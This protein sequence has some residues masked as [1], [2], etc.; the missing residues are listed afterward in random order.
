MNYSKNISKAIF[1]FSLALLFTFSSCKKDE[2]TPDDDTEIT[3]LPSV[4]QKIY[5]ASDIYLEGDFVVIKTNGT[6]DHKSPYYTDASKYEDYNGTNPDWNQNPNTISSLNFTFKI[7]LNPVKA[8]NNAATP[9]G[10]MGVSLNGVAFFNQYAGPNNQALTSEINSFD[11]YNGHPQQQGVY[12]YHIEPLYL[13]ST[14]GKDVLLGF[15]L[16]GFPVYGVTENGVAVDNSDLDEFHGHT[17]A[18]ADYPNGIYHYHI[19]NAAP[20]INGNGFYG[21]AGTVTQ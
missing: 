16:D 1:L 10:V 13:T 11:Q 15:L 12:H 14:K 2:T 17:H 9:L 7:P 19:T 6:P 18:T 5:G 8:S 4:Y 20:Y 21:T 3:E